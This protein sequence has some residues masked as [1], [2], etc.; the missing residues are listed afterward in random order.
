MT[1]AAQQA[2]YRD[3]LARGVR[4]V[5]VEVPKDFPDEWIARLEAYAKELTDD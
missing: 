5:V 3:R 2:R 1:T 4:T